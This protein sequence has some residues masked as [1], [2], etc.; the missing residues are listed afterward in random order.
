MFAV[1]DVV[2]MLSQGVI[3]FLSLCGRER[4][5]DRMFENQ[6]LVFLALKFCSFRHSK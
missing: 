3:K 5:A 4:E 2:G 6:T 1:G